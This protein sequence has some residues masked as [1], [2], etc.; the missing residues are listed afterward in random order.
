MRGV[1]RD[2]VF[3]LRRL[4]EEPRGALLVLVAGVLAGALSLAVWT[5]IDAAVLGS[6]EPIEVGGFYAVKAPASTPARALF[7]SKAASTRTGACR[8]QVSPAAS[9]VDDRSFWLERLDWTPRATPAPQPVDDT[10]NEAEPGSELRPC[11]F[12]A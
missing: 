4:A 3:G 8:G 7:W 11:R 10:R 9:H 5:H 12:E 2:L 1:I 6:L